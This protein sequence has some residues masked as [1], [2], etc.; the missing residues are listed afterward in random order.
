MMKQTLWPIGHRVVRKEKPR[1]IVARKAGFTSQQ[2]MKRVEK[3]AEKRPDLLEA[4]DAGKLTVGGAE[5]KMK[6]DEARK[7]QQAAVK[8]VLPV[9]RS[10]ESPAARTAQ[11]VDVVVEEKPVE[12]EVYRAFKPHMIQSEGNVRTVK[13]ADHD[14]LLE[15][16][17]YKQ[18]FESYNDAVQ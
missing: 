10:V 17:I 15:N 3:L 6:Q 18:L 16:P 1:D 2:Q 13:G 7:S 4:V 5:R 12:I 14:H 11:I 9:T 8:S